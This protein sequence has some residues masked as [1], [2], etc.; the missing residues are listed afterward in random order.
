M[1]LKRQLIGRSD[2]IKQ[3][4]IFIQKTASSNWNI[5]IQGETGV[6][7]EVVARLIHEKSNRNNYNFIKLNCAN[8]SENLLESEIFGHAKGAFTGADFLKAGL[9]EDADHGTLFMD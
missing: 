2:S 9:I 4:Q 8:L 3:I 5:L 6:G 1:I 7:K